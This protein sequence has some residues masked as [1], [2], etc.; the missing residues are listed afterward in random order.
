M[1]PALPSARGTKE[2][3]PRRVRDPCPTRWL[4]SV[5]EFE[6]RYVIYSVLLQNPT[7]GCCLCQEM[8]FGCHRHCR[9]G[10]GTVSGLRTWFSFFP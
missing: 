5:L 3:P 7:E 2:S 10:E 6:V 4:V 8:L 9:G 1:I